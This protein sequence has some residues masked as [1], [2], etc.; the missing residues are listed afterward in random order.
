MTITNPLRSLEF[1]ALGG[2]PAFDP[3]DLERFLGQRRIA[4]LAYVRRDGRPNQ[5]PIWYTLTDGVFYMSTVTNGAKHR[6]LQRSP[7]VSLSIQDER[8][9]YRA[10]IIEGT[11]ELAPLDP[12][13]DPTAG[14]ATRYFGKV[15][16]AAYDRITAETYERSGLTVVTVVPT[17]VKGFDNTNA[18]SAGE[19]AFTSVREFLPVPRA[20]L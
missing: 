4:T 6:A 17:A 7:R 12:N 15:A 11:A 18:L 20:W 5:A 8:P 9:P 19:R 2:Q 16:A 14:M 3:G 13:N 10:V 1:S